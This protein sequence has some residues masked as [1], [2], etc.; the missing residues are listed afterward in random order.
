MLAQRINER[1]EIEEK[2]SKYVLLKGFLQKKSIALIIALA[3]LVRILLA[4]GSYSGEKD[5]PNFGDFEA[6]RNWMSITVNRPIH[7]WY[8]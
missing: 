4:L 5:Y 6:H 7:S 1:A 8:E 2:V 3:I